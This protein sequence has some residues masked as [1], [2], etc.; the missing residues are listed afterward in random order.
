[1]RLVAPVRPSCALIDAVKSSSTSATAKPLNALRPKVTYTPNEWSGRT[2]E[3][4]KHTLGITC[5]EAV[6]V[7]EAVTSPV[8]P[9]LESLGVNVPSVLPLFDGKT[10][11]V[12]LSV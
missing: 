3:L 9:T 2:T 4:V 1:M 7:T 12:P 8:K 10:N 6:P 5:T 11:F